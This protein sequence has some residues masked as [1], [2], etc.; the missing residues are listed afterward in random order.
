VHPAERRLATTWDR[1]ANDEG[2][3]GLIVMRDDQFGSI[4]IVARVLADGIVPWNFLSEKERRYSRQVSRASG[5]QPTA[6]SGS[7]DMPVS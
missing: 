4:I 2:D 3:L 1:N 7:P 6:K 5:K